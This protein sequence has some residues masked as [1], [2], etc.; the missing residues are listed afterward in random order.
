M[1]LCSCEM[2]DFYIKA[3]IWFNYITYLDV[4]DVILISFE[5]TRREQEHLQSKAHI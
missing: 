5:D 2:T 4:L 1:R 3:F